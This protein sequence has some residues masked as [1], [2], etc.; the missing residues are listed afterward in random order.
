MDIQ[1]EKIMPD[2]IGFMGLGNLG[3]PIVSNLMAAGYQLTIYN[4]DASKVDP[5]VEHGA[6]RANRPADVVQTGGVVLSLL[7]DDASVEA[8]VRSEDFLSRLGIGGVHVSMTTL[9]PEARAG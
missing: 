1:T 7:W 2:A 9:S 4:R 5:F 8:I 3:R 6:V